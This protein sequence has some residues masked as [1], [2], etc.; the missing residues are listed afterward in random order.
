[1]VTVCDRA[2]EE[3]RIGDDW[4]HWSLPDPVETGTDEAF[5]AIVTE[6]DQRIRQLDTGGV[7]A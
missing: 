3:L 1:M 6:L 5:D 4:W 2:H 7:P